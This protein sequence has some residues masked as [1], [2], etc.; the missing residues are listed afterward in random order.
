LGAAVA[1]SCALAAARRLMH[2]A[3]MA[4]TSRRGTKD[5][6]RSRRLRNF[7]LGAAAG[8]FVLAVLYA[9][10]TAMTVKAQFEGRRWDLPAQVYAAPLELFA[11][12]ALAQDDLVA[13]VKRLGYREDPRL[14]SPGTYRVGL[15]R[16]EISTRGFDFAGDQ[17]PGRLVSIAFAGGRIAGLRDKQGTDAAIVR[18]NPLLIGS[19]FAAHGEDRLIVTPSDIPKLLPAT[20]KAVEDQRFDKHYGID[21]LAVARAM[22]VNVTSGEIKQGASTL[23]Q[24]LVR[25]YF[26]SNDRTWERKLREALMSIALEMRYDK[27]EIMDAYVNEIYL[28]QDGARAIHGFGLASQFYFGKPL[29]ELELHELALL[30][31]IVRGPTYYDPR[32]HPDRARERRNFVLQRMADDGLATN[33]AVQAA[34]EHDLGLVDNTRRSATQSAFLQLVRRQLSSEYKRDDLERTGLTVLST[35]DPTVQTAAER[36]LDTGLKALGKKAEKFEGAVVVTNPQT[37]EVQAIVGGRQADYEGFNR[38][39]DARRPIGSLIK[40]AVYLAALESQ[41]Y[42]LASILDDAPIEVKLT[43]GTTW[44]PANFDNVAHGPVPLVRAL[45]ESLN[46]AT[47]RLGLDVGLEQIADV[48]QRLGLQQKPRLYPSMLLGAL[49]LT[50]IEVAQVYNTLANGGFRVPLRT[51]R[52]V[53]GD[54]GKLLQ[55]YEI[56]INQASDPAYVYALNQGLVQV[57]ERGTGRTVRMQLPADMVVAGKTGTSDDLRDSWFAGF[58][59]DHLI[60]TWIG[61]DDNT[62]TGLTGGSGAARIWAGALHSLEASSYTAPAPDTVADQ[63]IDYLTGQPMAESCDNAVAVP[64]PL[65]VPVERAFGCNGETG[66]GAR[67]RGWFRG[68]GR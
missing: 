27:N 29:A 54:D 30:V 68:D 3:R 4:R 33:K 15:G 40:P 1:C 18:L 51:V 23:T 66:L 61:A 13:E 45:A 35:L 67:I 48:L 53:I 46:M 28:G 43:N 25:S 19:L 64:I 12:R 57:M 55:R 38:A 41:R 65:D 14:P 47:V 26:L 5:G 44:L 9:G 36:A 22:F 59:N 21:P 56:E 32:R 17:E 58:T 8:A 50:P 31:A 37:G 6:S 7:L 62:P 11:G 52:S 60:V 34:A 49:A 42:T 63:W 2:R 20:L 10:F 24:Q 16:M 39:L